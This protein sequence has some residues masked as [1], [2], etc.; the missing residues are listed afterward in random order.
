MSD[1]ANSIREKVVH[2]NLS[3][4]CRILNNFFPLRNLV[5]WHRKILSCESMICNIVS[6][7]FRNSSS[8]TENYRCPDC[9][10]STNFTVHHAK[11]NRHGLKDIPKEIMSFLE[12]TVEPCPKK[13]KEGLTKG[14]VPGEKNSSTLSMYLNP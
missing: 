13:C 12:T 6:R 10:Y 2:K 7:L 14:I 3:R 8:F 9:K 1:T 11:I 5:D 4:G